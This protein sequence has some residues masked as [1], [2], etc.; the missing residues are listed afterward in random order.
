MVWENH[1]ELYHFKWYTINQHGLS[2]RQNYPETVIAWYLWNY[3]LGK[4][5][6]MIDDLE[7]EIEYRWRR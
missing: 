2:K 3:I 1:Q 6:L 7:N 5:I 4:V